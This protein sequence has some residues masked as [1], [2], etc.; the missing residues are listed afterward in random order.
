M[1]YFSIRELLNAAV[2]SFLLGGALAFIYRA[3]FALI[4]CIYGFREIKAYVKAKINKS[5]HKFISPSSR[6]IENS[7][8][9]FIISEAVN[10]V[11]CLSLGPI[12]SI[13]FYVLTGGV[14]RLYIIFLFLCGFFLSLKV[15][16]KA[17]DAL[18]R[19]LTGIIARIVF[20][21]AY[22]IGYIP[23]KMIKK[24]QQGC[25]KNP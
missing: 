4:E 10:L 19:L 8:S 5:P 12:L 2:F 3:F 11:F 14:I 20:L 25:K 13:A 17:F 21:M 24:R 16:K 18:N 1:K 15:F 6:R 9:G 22:I 7:K 23:L